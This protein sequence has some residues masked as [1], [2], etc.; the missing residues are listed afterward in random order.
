MNDK[1][2]TNENENIMLIIIVYFN[3][4]KNIILL[5]RISNIKYIYNI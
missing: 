4:D 3:D 5:K 2:K 1:I